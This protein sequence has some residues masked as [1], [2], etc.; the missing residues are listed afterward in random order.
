ME[1]GN[2]TVDFCRHN[3]STYPLTTVVPNLAELITSIQE[4]AHPIMATIDVKDIFFM[5]PI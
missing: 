5:I 2:L 1:S 4:K 3:A